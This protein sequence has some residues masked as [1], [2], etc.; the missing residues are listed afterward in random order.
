MLRYRGVFDLL[1]SE[2]QAGVVGGVAID[3][4]VLTVYL[5]AHFHW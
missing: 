4:H 1:A 3:S 2:V 5:V